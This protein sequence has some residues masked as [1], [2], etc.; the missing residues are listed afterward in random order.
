MNYYKI[1]YRG[2]SNYGCNSHSFYELIVEGVSEKD[3]ISKLPNIAKL[4]IE[5]GHSVLSIENVE[6]ANINEY[7]NQLRLAKE[8][9]EKRVKRLIWNSYLKS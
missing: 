5:S 4:D 8:K 7:N 2:R 6:L 9:D 1:N 3:A